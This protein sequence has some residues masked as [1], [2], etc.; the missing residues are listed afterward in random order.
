MNKEDATSRREPSSERNVGDPDAL[1]RRITFRLTLLLTAFA[2]ATVALAGL[3]VIG[4][5]YSI[6]GTDEVELDIAFLTVLI[7]GLPLKSLLSAWIG[8]PT[9]KG[10]VLCDRDQAPGLWQELDLLFGD[11]RGGMPSRVRVTLEP[12]AYVQRQRVGWGVLG[13]RTELCVGLPLLAGLNREQIRCILA[14]ELYHLVHLKDR[15]AHAVVSALRLS[16]AVEQLAADDSW[17]ARWILRPIFHWQGERLVED[18]TLL[19]R[20]QEYQADAFAASYSSPQVLADTLLKRSLFGYRLGDSFWET[21]FRDA[22]RLGDRLQVAAAVFRTATV[23]GSMEDEL[24][25]LRIE[26]RRDELPDDTR[27]SFSNR[28][29]RL[30]VHPEGFGED[31][32]HAL[33]ETPSS[34]CWKLL[35]D[36]AE[37]EAIL[38]ELTIDYLGIVEKDAEAMRKGRDEVADAMRERGQPLSAGDYW[39]AALLMAVVEGDDAAVPLVNRVLDLE[40]RH[41][42]ARLFMA[43]RRLKEDPIAGEVVMWELARED[44]T[45]CA[46]AVEIL[47]EHGER[48]GDRDLLRKLAAFR[49]ELAANEKKLLRERERITRSDPIEPI[50]VSDEVLAALRR[51]CRKIKSLKTLRLAQKTNLEFFPE[52]PAV[53]AGI[54]TRGLVLEPEMLKQQ[55]TDLCSQHIHGTVHVSLLQSSVKHDQRH[56]L[57]KLEG[58]LVYSRKLHL[59]PDSSFKEFPKK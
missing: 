14:H 3:L 34:A 38:D 12:S 55:L 39:E 44:L 25:H 30:G 46:E 45:V 4:V 10:G 29:V 24:A 17:I 18:V 52:T 58:R 6:W 21:I 28:I 13:T 35:V 51:D 49:D 33:L 53:L 57:K 8:D 2:L 41:G 43:S 37:H 47:Q 5:W 31:H 7:L 36:T 23:I 20:V 27:P 59:N 22:L 54:E 40:P 26:I 9:P 48:L 32:L 50:A 15:R 42:S 19:S 1:A 56:R 11:L 16:A